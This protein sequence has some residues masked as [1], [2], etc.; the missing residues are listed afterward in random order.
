MVTLRAGRMPE[1]LDWS[2]IGAV[3]PLK[4][5]GFTIAIFITTL[6]FDDLESQEEA[7]LAIL[8]A[9]A[10]AAIVGLVFLFG[11]AAVTERGAR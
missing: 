3:T 1:G 7:K 11:R 4:G 9:S 8:V 6:A 10:T 2:S 5:I